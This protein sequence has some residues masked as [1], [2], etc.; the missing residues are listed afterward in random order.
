M[1]CEAGAV[2]RPGFATFQL[3][4]LALAEDYE[5]GLDEILLFR[6][7]KP[8]RVKAGNPRV[9]SHTATRLRGVFRRDG[10]MQSH[11][12]SL[13]ALAPS[14]IA[15]RTLSSSLPGGSNETASPAATAEHALKQPNLAHSLA[16]RCLTKPVRQERV[17]D[18]METDQGWTASPVVN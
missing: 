10:R 1:C 8:V 12:L 4:Q 16:T 2:S 18:D 7:A 13:A 17:I 5:A 6:N 11:C 9:F 15:L 3:S 14:G